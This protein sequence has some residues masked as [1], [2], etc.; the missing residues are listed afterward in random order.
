MLAVPRRNTVLQS[1]VWMFTR[2]TGGKVVRRERRTTD[3]LALCNQKIT[4]E[5]ALRDISNAVHWNELR[6]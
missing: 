3:E 2:G 6:R 1:N 4:R 5:I